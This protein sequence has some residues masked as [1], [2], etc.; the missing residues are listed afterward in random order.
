MRAVL[1][2]VSGPVETTRADEKPYREQ[3]DNETTIDF[4]VVPPKVEEAAR[5]KIHESLGRMKHKLEAANSIFVET[6]RIMESN[7]SRNAY[8]AG[9][10]LIKAELNDLE[11]SLQRIEEK[12]SEDQSYLFQKL[13]KKI[14]AREKELNKCLESMIED[15]R[16]MHE[17]DKRKMYDAIVRMN[18]RQDDE[19][20]EVK[21]TTM[22]LRK[23]EARVLEEESRVSCWQIIG[24]AINRFFQQ[25]RTPQIAP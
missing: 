11:N 4:E 20:K 5:I 18:Q 25:F 8:S 23:K 9:S 16:V 3:N 19:K 1:E 14:Y 6:G 15:A 7:G 12:N 21:N 10:E 13:S 17:R 22:L 2:S 24:A